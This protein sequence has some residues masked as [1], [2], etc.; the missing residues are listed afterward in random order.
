VAAYTGSATVQGDGAKPAPGDRGAPMSCEFRE[1]SE[2]GEWKAGL[3]AADCREAQDLLRE[4]IRLQGTE[5]GRPPETGATE[6]S[7]DSAER[8]IDY[9]TEAKG[10]RQLRFWIEVFHGAVVEVVEVSPGPKGRE[11]GVALVEVDGAL[12]DKI[13]KVFGQ[14]RRR[15][16]P[17]DGKGPTAPGRTFKWITGPYD[18]NE[19]P[20][21]RRV[22]EDLAVSMASALARAGSEC[23]PNVIAALADKEAVIREAAVRALPKMGPKAKDAIPALRK[24]RDG[25]PEPKVRQ[26]A[27]QALKHME[28]DGGSGNEKPTGMDRRDL[29]AICDK[30]SR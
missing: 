6:R 21:P 12:E 11:T 4:V 3:P 15:A 14:A 5:R 17:A 13:E 23:I 1:R 20:A 16:E 27:Q 8:R 7:H 18:P 25:D 9:L 22:G 2:R 29:S 28:R 30:A 24:L 19:E 26:A 10:T